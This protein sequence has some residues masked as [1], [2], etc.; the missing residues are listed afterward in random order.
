MFTN[1]SDD[2]SPCSAIHRFDIHK[3][4]RFGAERT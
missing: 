2:G 4:E 1:W 3:S